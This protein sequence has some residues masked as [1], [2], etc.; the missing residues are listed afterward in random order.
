MCLVAFYN[1][2]WDF[3]ALRELPNFSSQEVQD[4]A[5]RH[6][7]LIGNCTTQG[8]ECTI[9]PSA[10]FLV[11]LDP[12]YA[13]PVPKS[14]PPDDTSAS[15]GAAAAPP[16]MV[17][18]NLACHRTLYSSTR[19]PNASPTG[20]LGPQTDRSFVECTLAMTASG[21]TCAATSAW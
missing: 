17:K 4:I 14:G 16:P 21:L 11:H 5:P 2:I 8:A 3:L 15:T 19:V 10:C 6:R 20:Y 9:E 18:M 12:S 1:M 13:S 7:S